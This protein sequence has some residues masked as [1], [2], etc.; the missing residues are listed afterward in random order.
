[1]VNKGN[2]PIMALILW[3]G[4]L[5]MD[6]NMTTIAALLQIA[7]QPVY[8]GRGVRLVHKAKQCCHVTIEEL[9]GQTD[10]DFLLIQ[11]V[12]EF[13]GGVGSKETQKAYI[14]NSLA[15]TFLEQGYPIDW[16]ASTTGPSSHTSGPQTDVS[17][18]AIATWKAEAGQLVEVMR[19]L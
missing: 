14:R 1:M 10:A 4:N 15:G 8:L 6:M 7:F 11:L 9:S 13:S 12:G 2:H 19:R 16:V 17:H 5:P 3:D 18:H